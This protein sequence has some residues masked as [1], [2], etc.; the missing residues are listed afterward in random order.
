MSNVDIKTNAK[1]LGVELTD[2]MVDKF[3]HY[4]KMVIEYNQ[5][6]NL[7]AITDE[8]EFIVKH[9]LDSISAERFLPKGATVVDIGSGA[10]FP[11][12][13]LKIVRDDLKFTLLDALNKRV[14]FLKLVAEDL[15]LSGVT[16]VHCRAEDAG[17]GVLRA[18][19][20]VAIA[21]A[22][23]DLRTLLEYAI[24]LL[25]VGGIFIAYKGGD[26]AELN[27]AENALHLLNCKVV[28]DYR[29]TLPV[30]GDKRSLIVIKKI[31]ETS[32]RYPRGGGKEKKM[33]L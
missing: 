20:D 2:G 3:D 4:Y 8:D 28:E 32:N 13:P 26:C 27:S 22:V 21:R 15:Q 7:T 12:L 29:F 23:A 25:K 19:F 1:L 5:K 24:P 9:Y 14:S 6:V 31:G 33:P 10:G 18:T 16:C 11:A 17:Q 30:S